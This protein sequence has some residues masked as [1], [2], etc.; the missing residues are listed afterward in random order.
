MFN[1]GYGYVYVAG[2]SKRIKEVDPCLSLDDGRC[3]AINNFYLGLAEVK[4]NIKQ[5]VLGF[6][7]HEFS[8]EATL[9]CKF[10]ENASIKGYLNYCRVEAIFI[11]PGGT[12]WLCVILPKAKIVLGPSVHDITFEAMSISHRAWKKEFPHLLNHLGRVIY[13]F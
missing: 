7:S 5:G 1:L 10:D 9:W 6:P 2:Y 3:R 11:L 12:G 8:N 4:T 13:K